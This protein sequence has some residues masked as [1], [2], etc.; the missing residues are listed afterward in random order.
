MYIIR[1]SFFNMLLW[2]RDISTPERNCNKIMQ[3]FSLSRV[4]LVLSFS[5]HLIASQDTPAFSASPTLYPTTEQPTVSP[6]N[7]PA[8]VPRVLSSMSSTIVPTNMPS[9]NFLIR[10][11]FWYD[12]VTLPFRIVFDVS[13]A[14][15]LFI[16]RISVVGELFW[17]DRVNSLIG[18]VGF[19]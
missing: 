7:Y 6:S 4:V 8:A 1:Y 10:F 14:L 18:R 15:F 5:V 12:V 3:V 11:L 13:Y 19:V 17:I 9:N 16:M 2:T